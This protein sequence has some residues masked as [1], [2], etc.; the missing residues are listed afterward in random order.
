MRFIQLFQKFLPVI[1]RK[2]AENICFLLGREPLQN[3]L[4][5]FD[6]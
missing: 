1:R 4:K 5:T 3:I 2:P 6:G